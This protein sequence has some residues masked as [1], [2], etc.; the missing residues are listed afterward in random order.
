MINCICIYSYY[1]DFI[2][3]LLTN[4]TYSAVP[5]LSTVTLTLGCLGISVMELIIGVARR[6]RINEIKTLLYAVT[7]TR[8]AKHHEPA[9]NR[10]P[11]FLNE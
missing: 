11:K 8:Q 10:I 5:P 7:I 1:K 3:N 2:N 4:K 6:L 9:N